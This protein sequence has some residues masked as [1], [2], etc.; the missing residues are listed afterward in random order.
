MAEY[1][2]SWHSVRVTS[3]RASLPYLVKQV[4]LAVRK[5]LDTTLA[6]YGLTTTQYTLLTALERHANATAASLARRSFVTAQTMAQLLRTLEERGWV[7][8]HPDPASRRQV[9]ITLAPAGADLLLKLREPVA[10]IERRMTQHLTEAQVRQLEPL[11]RTMRS[12][13]ES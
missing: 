12:S 5:R 7:E 11:L 8:R 3:E 6:A 2:V 1:Q 9:R 10:G 4:E 13:L